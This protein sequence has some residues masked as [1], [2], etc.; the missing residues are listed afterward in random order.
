MLA[1]LTVSVAF[2]AT[3]ELGA[4]VI[5]QSSVVPTLTIVIQLGGV[6]HEYEVP[7]GV[8]FTVLMYS[9]AAIF[10]FMFLY[11]SCFIFMMMGFLR[12]HQ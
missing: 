4:T 1:C 2:L 5:V 11:L 6:S 12:L 3:P 9:F 7:R 10:I 8:I